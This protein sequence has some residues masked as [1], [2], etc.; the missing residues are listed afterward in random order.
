MILDPWQNF[1][2]AFHP[3]IDPIKAKAGQFQR[4]ASSFKEWT[5]PSFGSGK[6]SDIK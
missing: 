6:T 4:T 2:K 1:T 5:N 3:I